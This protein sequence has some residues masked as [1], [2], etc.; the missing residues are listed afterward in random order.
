MCEGNME[1]LRGEVEA[2]EIY[3]G[4]VDRNRRH[5]K[6][7][8]PGSGSKKDK[9]SI[10]GVRE[11]ETGRVKAQMVSDTKGKTLQNFVREN[12]EPGSLLYTDENRGY[13]HLSENYGGEYKHERVKHSAKEFVNGM[14]HTSG[15]ESV[16]AVLKRG[17]NGV[18]HNWSKKHCRAYVNEFT[19]RL[20]EGNCEIDTK[21]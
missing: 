17:F 1:A 11:R 13:T 8:N 4:G 21:D 18:Y 3:L 16:W 15:I 5:S 14:A 20:N 10:V 6:K 9:V 2:N 12:V 19:F 7:I